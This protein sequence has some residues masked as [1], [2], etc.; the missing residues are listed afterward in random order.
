LFEVIGMKR[1]I[2]IEDSFLDY[3]KIM[4]VKLKLKNLSEAVGITIKAHKKIK[5]RR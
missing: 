3:L 1:N 4:K 2:Q 5:K